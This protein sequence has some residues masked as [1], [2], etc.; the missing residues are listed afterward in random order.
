MQPSSSW[1]GYRRSATNPCDLLTKSIEIKIYK[2]SK[3]HHTFQYS[4]AVLDHLQSILWVAH[5]CL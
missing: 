2:Q 1:A 4:T 5:V 3:K